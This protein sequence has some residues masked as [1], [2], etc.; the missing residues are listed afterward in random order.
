MHSNPFTDEELNEYEYYIKPRI[1]ALVKN[2]ASLGFQPL[3][4]DDNDKD[5]HIEFTDSDGNYEDWS[6]DHD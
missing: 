5:T 3:V 6:E 2:I 1:K 4:F